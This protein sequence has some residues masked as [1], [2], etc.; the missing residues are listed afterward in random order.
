MKTLLLDLLND[1]C[2]L[3]DR[4]LKVLLQIVEDDDGEEAVK[5]IEDQITEIEIELRTCPQDSKIKRNVIGVK[6]APQKSP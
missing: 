4:N 3:S 1:P 5:E 6:P 2:G